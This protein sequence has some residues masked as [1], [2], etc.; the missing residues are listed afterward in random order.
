MIDICCLVRYQDLYERMIISARKTAMTEIGF[1]VVKDE[2]LP[3]LAKAY[4]LMASR[5]KA[6]ILLF[7]HDDVEFISS[8][9]DTKLIE[10]LGDFDVAGVCGTTRYTGGRLFNTGL[11]Y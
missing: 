11:D 6:D 8:A 5:S 4:N 1:R 2:G 7:V 3:R 10:A 9:W